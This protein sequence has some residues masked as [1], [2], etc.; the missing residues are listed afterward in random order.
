MATLLLLPLL[1][2]SASLAIR[3][4]GHSVCCV[5]CVHAYP[6]VVCVC[7]HV[8]K[9]RE[10]TCIYIVHVYMYMYI[11][12]ATSTL[13]NRD[14][15]SIAS[16]YAKIS[17]TTLS[18]QLPY[19]TVWPIC[20]HKWYKTCPTADDVVQ[21]EVHTCTLYTCTCTCTCIYTHPVHVV[22]PPPVG[23]EQDV[24]EYATC[25]LASFCIMYI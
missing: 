6:R 21:V 15:S 3:T 10:S 5:V 24:S 8:C 7:V 17:T 12:F 18:T 14:L 16:H 11:V 19:S 20:N 1:T 9:R 4:L 2:P 22:C 25:M 13:N 23:R